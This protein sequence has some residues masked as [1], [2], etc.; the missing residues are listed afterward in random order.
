MICVCV[1]VCVLVCVCRVMFVAT[2]S[3]LRAVDMMSLAVSLTERQRE[4]C[5]LMLSTLSCRVSGSEWQLRLYSLCVGVCLLW[6][7]S[8]GRLVC[9]FSDVED[10]TIDQRG[11]IRLSLS[12]SV[13]MCVCVSSATSIVCGGSADNSQI[14]DP[15]S[16]CERV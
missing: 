3:Q 10:C 15:L 8:R 16:V 7:L 4:I 12:L 14:S 6:I 5:C 2:T 13:C 9:V 11:I 1:C